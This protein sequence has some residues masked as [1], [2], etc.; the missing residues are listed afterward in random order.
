MQEPSST[1]RFAKK[2][3][4]A[5][6]VVICSVLLLA[7]LY[8]TFNVILLIFAAALLAIFL[9]GLAEIVANYVKVADGWL[10][11]LVSL[12]LVLLIGGFIAA[13]SPSIAEQ[14]GLLR[15]KLPASVQSVTE[16]LSRY[17][18]GRTLIENLPSYDSVLENINA[19]NLM[20][21]VGGVFSSTMGVLGNIAI[22]LLLAVYLASEPRLYLSGFLRLFPFSQRDRVKEV[23]AGIYQTLRWWLIGKAASM[24]FIGIL[25]WIGLSIIGVPLA[26][27]LGLIAGLLSFIP[28]FGP[29]ISA[30][31]AILLA[32]IDSPITAVYVLGLYVGVQLIESNV[33]TPFIERETVELP[34]ALTIVFQLALGVLVGGMGLVLATPI[35]A[36]AVVGVQ[37]LYIEDVLGDSATAPSLEEVDTTELATDSLAE[38]E[39][40]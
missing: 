25:T 2:V 6:A 1:K 33:V 14:A 35:L 9:R 3:L 28:N 5:S 36:A 18:W 26:L 29:I 19:S 17:G 15:E 13:L 27:T 37:M 24:L 31:P 20:Y 23:I 11:L 7:A 32:F 39:S 12:L 30:I 4:I 38:A 22:V 8:C 34:P 21:G 40:N 16:F 10:V